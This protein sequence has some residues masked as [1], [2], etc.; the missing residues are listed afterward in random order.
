MEIPCSQGGKVFEVFTLTI[1][2]RFQEVHTFSI[3]KTVSNWM[4]YK[5]F[6]SGEKWIPGEYEPLQIPS[7]LKVQWNKFITILS[8][9]IVTFS[10]CVQAWIFDWDQNYL[11]LLISVNLFQMGKQRRKLFQCMY[12]ST[13]FVDHTYYHHPLLFRKT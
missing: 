1:L 9:I 5:Y 3:E 4:P 11:R 7:G 8:C 13:V 10:I 2:P 12:N 6:C